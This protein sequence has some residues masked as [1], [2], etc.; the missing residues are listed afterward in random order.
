VEFDCLLPLYGFCGLSSGL[1]VCTANAFALALG[2]L[3]WP[4]LFVYL[5]S[6]GLCMWRPEDHLQE[7]VFFFHAMGSEVKTGLLCWLLAS[8][9]AEPCHWPSSFLL[10]QELM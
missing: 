8:L 5:F 6:V 7:S 3:I 1:Q 2:Q 9:P 10:R 4:T